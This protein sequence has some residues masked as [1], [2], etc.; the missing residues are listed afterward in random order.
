MLQVEDIAK[1]IRHFVFHPRITHRYQYIN[2]LVRFLVPLVLMVGVLV[3]GDPL[4]FYIFTVTNIAVAA[5]LQV[6][7]R[8]WSRF[9]K[10]AL[11][12]SIFTI[13]VRAFFEYGND[14]VLNVGPLTVT[15]EGLASANWY[16]AMLLAVCA[17]LVLLTSIL[18]L[19]DL[20]HALELLGA[21]RQVCYVVI[22]SARLIP[23]LAARGTAVRDAQ[24]SRGIQVDGSR[25]VKLKAVVPTIAPLV[26][27]A[28][29]SVEERAVAMEV[30]G[31][32]ITE[33]NG[34]RLVPQD[35]VSGF[36]YM[37]LIITALLAVF[38]GV[39]GRLLW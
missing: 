33:I 21:R 17:P 1:D 18:S 30:R 2:P 5:V 26:L 22:N 16:V 23:E 3:S 20:S 29:S 25:L 27:S 8:F 14:V 38:I 39:G 9:W 24:R 11:T 19:Q 10:I 31:A 12:V 37:C 15:Q 6:L 35:K 7:D 32:S 28:L 13:G 36:E 34:T 4:T